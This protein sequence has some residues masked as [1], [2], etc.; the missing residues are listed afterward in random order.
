MIDLR[1]DD[2]EADLEICEMCNKEGIRYVHIMTHPEYGDEVNAGQVC[3]QNMENDYAN[4][5]QR[6]RDLLNRSNRKI[7]F[8]RKEWRL[9]DNGNYVLRFKGKNITIIPSKYNS[10]QYGVAYN[11][12]FIWDYKGKKIPD[13]E[14]AKRA[15]FEIYDEDNRR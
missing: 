4:P 2:P 10:R 5:L 12:Q 8:M 1:E 6:E 9:N 14:T 11:N 7:T 15:A 13:I 3:A